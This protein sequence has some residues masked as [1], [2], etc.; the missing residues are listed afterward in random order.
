[1]PITAALNMAWKN[2]KNLDLENTARIS[3]FAYSHNNNHIE[4]TG[5]FL[6]ADYIVHSAQK[7]VFLLPGSEAE[8]DDNSREEVDKK[9]RKE[10]NDFFSLLILHYL[11]GVKDIPLAN[12]WISFKEL[13]SGGFY[14]SSFEQ[15]CI[16]G[17]LDSFGNNPE[18][19]L[20]TVKEA[21]LKASEIDIGDVGIKVEV[22]SKLPICF[23][24][25]AGEIDEGLP[26]SA[27]VLFDR[28]AGLFLP[29]EDLSAI[30]SL[31]AGKLIK[32]N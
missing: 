17:I 5:N 10:V 1:M 21:R 11:I 6:D 12:E 31:T 9:N 29:T 15:K 26:P 16:K 25:W 28:T 7:K 24:V 32:N 8:P 13:P 19:L 27:T 14:F 20:K 4:L 3:G 2:L 23:A 30:A 22:F 18:E